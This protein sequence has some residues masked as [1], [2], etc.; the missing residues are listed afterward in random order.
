MSGETVEARRK[1]ETVTLYHGSKS[2]L[3]GPIAPISRNHCDFGRGFYMGTE[4]RQPFT[5]ICNYPKSKIY[6]VQINHG[7]L[8]AGFPYIGCGNGD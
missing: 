6:T 3:N 4:K 7:G 1:N 2:G 8:L 5:L